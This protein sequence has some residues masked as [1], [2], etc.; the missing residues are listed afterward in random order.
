MSKKLRSWDVKILLLLFWKNSTYYSNYL[1]YYHY[2]TYKE[3]K[4]LFE[5]SFT[6]CGFRSSNIK[7]L[8]DNPF[9][10]SASSNSFLKCK[11]YAISSLSLW[12]TYKSNSFLNSS[13]LIWWY[14][15]LL[16]RLWN[17]WPCKPTTY[18][19]PNT[20]APRGP[21]Q[22]TAIWESPIHVLGVEGY[23]K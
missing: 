1:L 4:K 17:W 19:Q 21:R 12:C 9:Y 22:P 20:E 5:Y 10:H 14:C 16:E 18:L 15:T 2:F 11:C 7:L 23:N 3:K 13:S 8:F 6:K